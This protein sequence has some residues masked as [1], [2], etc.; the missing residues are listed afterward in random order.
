MSD[1]HEDGRNGDDANDGLSAANAVLTFT[2]L[3]AVI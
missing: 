2:R 1:F 3:K